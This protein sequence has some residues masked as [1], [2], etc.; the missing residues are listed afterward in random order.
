MYLACLAAQK[1]MRLQGDTT[2]APKGCVVP[3][4]GKVLRVG[5][6][7]KNGD[8]TFVMVTK[9]VITNTTK[10]TGYCIDVL[11]ATMAA[12]PFAVRYEY[13]PFERALGGEAGSYYDKVN[14]VYQKF[15]AVIGDV[16]I[17]ADRSKYVD[18]TLPYTESGVTMIVP[19]KD[20]NY[21]NAWVFL[22]A[23]DLGSM[24]NKYLQVLAFLCS[25]VL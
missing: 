12:L 11:D 9:D 14:M 4:N 10:V 1:L 6:P 24:G 13:I 3:I 19:F 18:F 21:K 16:I 2:H 25:L 17:R 22:E 20:K 23:I 5:V 7:V 8:D 15:D